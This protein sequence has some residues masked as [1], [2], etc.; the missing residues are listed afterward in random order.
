MQFASGFE[1]GDGE[2]AMEMESE[3]FKS[4][5]GVKPQAAGPLPSVTVA[6]K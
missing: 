5:S 4:K 2:M 3:E 1:A 6:Q